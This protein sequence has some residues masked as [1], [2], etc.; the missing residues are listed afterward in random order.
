MGEA[1]VR[2]LINQGVIPMP[3]VPE[4]PAPPGYDQDP[5]APGDQRQE[6][7]EDNNELRADRE[8]QE[9]TVVKLHI[10]HRRL[11]TLDVKYS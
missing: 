11:A 3:N 6:N 8:D 2:A 7:G 9:K 1:V 10:T 4:G 5:V